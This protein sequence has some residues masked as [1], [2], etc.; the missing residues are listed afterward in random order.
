L[1]DGGAGRE[2]RSTVGGS[3]TTG[4]TSLPELSAAN[5][6]SNKLVNPTKTAATDAQV[7]SNGGFTASRSR[8]CAKGFF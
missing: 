6:G 2:P 4:R 8:L 5:V 1:E 7:F 3:T